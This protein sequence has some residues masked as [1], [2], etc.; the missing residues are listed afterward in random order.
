MEPYDQN[1]L[2]QLIINSVTSVLEQG[3]GAPQDL[4]ADTELVGEDS[5]LDSIGVIEL[6]TSLE[7][8][9]EEKHGIVIS[10]FDDEVLFDAEGPF[11]R[12]SKLAGHITEVLETEAANGD[13]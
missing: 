11:N 10:L 4:S 2:I 8:A 3:E 7:E 9:I 6:V 12:I 1:E 5:V 13:C